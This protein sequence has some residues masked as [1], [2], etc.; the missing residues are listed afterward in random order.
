M[1]RAF[2]DGEFGPMGTETPDP[3]DPVYNP[4]LLDESPDD[5]HRQSEEEPT[6]PDYAA[7]TAAKSRQLA[8]TKPQHPF[9][10]SPER[11]DDFLPF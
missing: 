2:Y 10:P 7:W 1:P 6:P 3:N 4:S 8:P 9:T 5:P 11:H